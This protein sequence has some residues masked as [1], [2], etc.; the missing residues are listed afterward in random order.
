M[1]WHNILATITKL[2]ELDELS[3]GTCASALECKFKH[4]ASNRY[5]SDTLP[6]PFEY[7]ELIPGSEKTILTL[8]LQDES[9][10]AEYAMRMLGL[11]KPVDIAIISPPLAS[12]NTPKS[13]LDWDGKY[14]LCYEIGEQQVWFGIEE[15]ESR[16]RLV[17]VS[18]QRQHS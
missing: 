5:R 12:E 3:V 2:I 4:T 6:D 15:K 17:S 1:T 13:E 7:A 18:I 10:R 8:A 9:A 16:K 14:S 11:G